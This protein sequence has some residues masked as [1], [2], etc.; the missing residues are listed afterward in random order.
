MR[1]H[2]RP[3]VDVDAEL[4][5]ERTQTA[6]QLRRVHEDARLLR[7]PAAQRLGV[8]L[9]LDG[10]PIEARHAVDPEPRGGLQLLVESRVLLGAVRHHEHA[11]RHQ[12]AVDPLRLDELA[13]RVHRPDRC[14]V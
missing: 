12:V 14:E 5:R 7:D 4:H 11:V 8:D 1:R 3:L 9:R 10:G 2:R 13:E 6:R